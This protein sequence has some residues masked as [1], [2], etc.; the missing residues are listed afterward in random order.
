MLTHNDK[1]EKF[2]CHSCDFSSSL[3]YL[4]A[5]HLE[6]VH[7]NNIDY[8]CGKCDYESTEMVKFQTHVKYCLRDTLKFKCGKCLFVTDR[9]EILKSHLLSH[10][11]KIEKFNCHDCDLSFSLQYLLDT[12]VKN[13][14]EKRKE[15]KCG[16]CFYTTT[17][18]LKLKTHVCDVKNYIFMKLNGKPIDILRVL[19]L[20]EELAKR[21][22]PK[23][24]DKQ[25][26]QQRLANYLRQNP[27]ECDSDGPDIWPDSVGGGGSALIAASVQQGQV[28]HSKQGA[29]QWNIA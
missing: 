28:I 29:F 26:L 25:R 10:D 6:S 13:F 11:D 19:D 18:N 8:K 5:Q 4:L 22:L 27:H 2:K 1:T 15:L 23:H 21:D 3:P 24:G 20:K 16:K 14:H 9:E 17:D 12:H 7:V